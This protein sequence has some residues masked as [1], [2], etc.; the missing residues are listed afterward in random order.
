MKQ[1]NKIYEVKNF[2]LE[3]EQLLQYETLFHNANG[4]LGVRSNFEEGYP[5]SYQTVRGEYINGFYNFSRM[6]QAEKLCGLTEEKQVMPNL[7]DTQGIQLT[8]CG[9]PFSMFRGKILDSARILDMEKGVTIRRVIWRSPGQRELEIEITRMTSFKMLPLF[10]IEYRVRALN[11][12]GSI[13]FFSTHIGDVRNSFSSKDPRVADGAARHL[14]PEAA[15]FTPEGF[16]TITSHTTTSRLTAV[17]M[18]CNRLSYPA[19]ESREARGP[20]A[21]QEFRLNLDQGHSVTLTKYT[22]LCDSVHY[23]N[24]EDLA[25]D[26]MK[27]AVSVPLSDWYHAQERYLKQFWETGNI[28]L[29][30]D[31]AL[32]NAIT[33]NLYQ[34]IQSVGK[35]PHSNIAAKGLSGEGY[36]GHYF[37]DTEMYIEPYFLLTRPSLAKNLIA[38][39]YTTLDAARRNARILGHRKGALYPW[40]T[41]MG[42]ECSGYFPSGSAQYHIN[43]DIAYS[44]VNYY[45]TTKDFDFMVHCGAEILFETAR[46]WM[47]VGNYYKGKFRINCVT[48]PDEYTCLVNNNY[49]TNVIARYN[50]KWAARFYRMM[51]E[52]NKISPLAERL[53]LTREEILSFQQ[54]A[55]D[56]Y[57]PYNQE[58]DINP[59]DDSFLSKEKWDFSQ[60]PPDSFPL[61]MHVHPLSLYRRQVCKQAD[62][63]LAHFILEDE[64]PLSTMRHSYDYYEKITT[65]DSSLSSCIFCIMAARFGMT[66]KAYSY[67][68]KSAQTDLMNTH[69]N[70]K[71]GLHIANMGGVY[72]SIVYGFGGLRIKED[73]LHLAP[74]LPQKWGGYSFKLYFEN[75]LLA[76]SVKHP[77]C[78]ITLLSGTEK[79][80][81]FYG[82]AHQLKDRLNIPL[83]PWGEKI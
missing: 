71:D 20:A 55:D 78:E 40:R 74:V 44:V 13:E 23:Q 57:L 46:L 12:S 6:N 31:D 8:V 35:D 72:M 21:V 19:A 63:I 16:S 7:V 73:G 56:M 69:G 61:L 30:G 4:Y 24:C 32:Q 83:E 33:Y 48:G 80:L 52:E 66:E 77:V 39:R 42:R 2:S 60:T 58:L 3:N 76:I 41:I 1:K 25:A 50:L 22:V 45:L 36:E 65:H 14:R 11:F 37:W 15:V 49:Y 67:F 64:Q 79:T 26:L 59:Q 38:F 10:T 70:T 18:V 51:T 62:T 34:L 9:E 75:S 5:D 54:A 17:S 53:C 81:F 47:D 28:Q 68:G 29:E 43:G 27:Q 82:K